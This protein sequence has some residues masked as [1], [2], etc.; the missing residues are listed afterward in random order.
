MAVLIQIDQPGSGAPAGVPGVA[1]EDLRIGFDVRLTAVGGP[2]LAYQWS[3]ID[4]PIDITL[5]VQSAAL[6]SAPSAIQT[7]VTP[8]D[9]AGTY[10][11][12][13][14][15]DSGLGLGARAEDVARITFYAGPALNS[16]AADPAELPRREI[17]FR[18]RTEHNVPETLFPTGNPR[19]WA[20][21]WLRWRAV[22]DRIY[23]SVQTL[24]VCAFGA[25]QVQGVAATPGWNVLGAFELEQAFSRLRL[26]VMHFVSAGPLTSRVRLFDLTAGAEV[27]GS[28]LSTSA[29][30]ETRQTSGDLA[31]LVTV[32]NTY[33]LQAECTG[34]AAPTDF[35]VVRYLTLRGD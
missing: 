8:V 12:Q 13:V 10:L 25:G 24:R 16:L 1:R 3:I 17:A 29:A 27:A 5:P 2:F 34:G 7:L 21:E 31:S 4:R 18:E 6:L 28:S 9:L 33:Q 32:G 35:S 15:V 11:V 26:D 30:S 20:Q 14:A 23:R 19:G 22:Y